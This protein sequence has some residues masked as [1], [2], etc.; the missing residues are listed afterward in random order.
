MDKL[1]FGTAGIPYSTTKPSTIS[2]IERVSELGLGAMELEFVRSVNLSSEKAKEVKKTA[3]KNNVALTCHASYYINFNSPEK[4]KV[5]ASRKRLLDAAKIANEAGALSV[6]F[7]PAF[8]MKN[9]VEQ[10]Y[11]NVKKEIE[12][13]TETLTKQKNNILVRPE[14]TGKKSAFGSLEEIVEL[15]KE[16]PNVLPCID[17]SHLHARENGK[18]NSEKEWRGMF[19]YLEKE[20]GKT[21][22]KNLHCHLSG[23]EY[24]EKGERK[25]LPMKES[26][27]KYKELLK[28]IKDFDCAGIIIC[29]SPNIEEDALLFKKIFESL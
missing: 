12:T 15:S 20:L 16:I 27:L 17:F 8:Y 13:I 14:T 21:Y 18:M 2:G 10:V 19:S 9:P 1:R 4:E 25:H 6:T 29:E 24:T 28:V 5:L 11:S 23:I 3:E 7:H 26:D 22:L